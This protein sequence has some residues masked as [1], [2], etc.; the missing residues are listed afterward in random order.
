M[1]FCNLF[2]SFEMRTTCESVLA[3]ASMCLTL[4]FIEKSHFNTGGNALTE[5]FVRKS[6]KLSLFALMSDK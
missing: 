5:D 6:A 4:N 3:G 1:A 2:V